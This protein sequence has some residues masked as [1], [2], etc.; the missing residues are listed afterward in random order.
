[1]NR[2][3]AV[4]KEKGEASDASRSMANW[5]P[6]SAGQLVVP[7]EEVVIC[8]RGF[9]ENPFGSEPGSRGRSCES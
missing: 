8:D 3:S 5:L 2:E 6:R 4:K 1:M 9:S 7:S